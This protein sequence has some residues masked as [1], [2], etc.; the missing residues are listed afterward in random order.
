MM[1]SEKLDLIISEMQGMKADIQGIK[2]DIQGMKTKI[3]KL[4]L[5][6]LAIKKDIYMIERRINDTYN[7]A[8]DALGMSAENRK[9]L[10]TGTLMM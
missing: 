8:L 5:G 3:D 9:W 6:Q 2:A 1:E 7:V 4:A 10:E